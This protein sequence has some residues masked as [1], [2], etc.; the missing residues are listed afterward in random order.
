ME[1]NVKSSPEHE[2]DREFAERV[3]GKFRYDIRCL[4]LNSEGSVHNTPVD[5]SVI[6]RTSAEATRKA[7]K[8][9]QELFPKSN[10]KSIEV[11]NFVCVPTHII[12]GAENDK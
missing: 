7:V 11:M 1:T 4:P 8:F 12:V 2:F 10:V 5:L 6:A 9:M 3:G